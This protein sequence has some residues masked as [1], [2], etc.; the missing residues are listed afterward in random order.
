V[1]DSGS[2]VQW[3]Q[4]RS[5]AVT[6]AD[7]VMGRQ[8]GGRGKDK[9]EDADTTI[10]ACDSWRRRTTA[11]TCGYGDRRQQQWQ[12]QWQRHLRRQWWQAATVLGC[13]FHRIP[14]GFR[15]KLAKVTVRKKCE[16]SKHRNAL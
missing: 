4:R 10:A 7:C 15:R 5:I 3:R 12:W 14:A 9:E 8:Q 2:C 13:A 11:V 1:F 6:M 16:S